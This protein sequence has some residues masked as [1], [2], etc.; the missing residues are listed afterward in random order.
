MVIVENKS[1]KG[2]GKRMSLSYVWAEIQAYIYTAGGAIIVALGI[3]RLISQKWIDKQTKK[4]LKKYQHELDSQLVKVQKASDR[5]NHVMLSL[6]DEEKEAVKE[7][8]SLLTSA[9]EKVYG[10]AYAEYK[11]KSQ[12]KEHFGRL[13]EV[14][15]DNAKIAMN[16]HCIFLEEDIFS[17]SEKL[18]N[19]ALKLYHA[20][21]FYEEEDVIE[22]TIEEPDAEIQNN[23]KLFADELLKQHHA[24]MQDMRKYLSDRKRKYQGD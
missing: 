19:K 15:I 16:R 7:I 11:P 5:V 14:S 17:S 10:F 13:C 6:Y 3:F 20:L 8:S 12:E 21:L 24:L 23:P 1:N 4:S 22:R 18:L 2:G 9:V